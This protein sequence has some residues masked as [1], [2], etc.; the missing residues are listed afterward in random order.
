MAKGDTK[1]NQYLD[2]AANGSRADLPSD[3][4]CETRSQ[5][6]I[7]E[8]AE[9]VMDVEDEVEEIKNNPDVVDIVDTYADL[10]DYDTSGLTDNDIIRVLN[11]ETRDGDSTYYRWSASTQSWAYIG[12]AGGA[13][14]TFTT[15]TDADVNYHDEA[16]GEDFIALWLLESGRYALA[17]DATVSLLLRLDENDTPT[18]YFS[19]ET[20]PI[21]LVFG[22]QNAVFYTG[23]A[24][25]ADVDPETGQSTDFTI[26]SQPFVGTDGT[27][28]GRQ[29]L[30]PTPE[31]IDAGMFLSSSGAWEAISGGIKE[32]TTDDYNWP[33]TGTPTSVALWLLDDGV[34]SFNNIQVRYNASMGYTSSGLAIT[35]KTTVSSGIGNGQVL[36]MPNGDLPRF[37]T[38]IRIDGT[39]ETQRIFPV[40][41]NNLTTVVSN[42][43]LD[44]RQGKVLKDMI[45]NLPT[46]GGITELTTADYNYPADN[47]DGIALWKLGEGLYSLPTTTGLKVYYGA[48]L[49]TSNNAT[50]DVYI[51]GPTTS[52]SKKVFGVLKNYSSPYQINY[53]N[54]N[55]G[56]GTSTFIPS[57]VQS[58]GTSQTDVMSQNAV[59]SM[60]YAD[61]NTRTRVQIGVGASAPQSA[62]YATAIGREA[63]ALSDR[64]VTLGTSARV[65]G[66][67]YSVA[68]A[69]GLVENQQGVF[70][71]G[72]N[73]YAGQATSGYNNSAYRLLTGLYDGQSAHDAATVAQGNTLATAAPT[74]ATEGVLG[75][76]YTDTTN[77]HTYQ[78]TSIDATDPSN[79]VYNWTQRW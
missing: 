9:R 7:R 67:P 28:P 69:Y 13:T 63:E 37:V 41:A 33:T 51:V 70:Q 10:E 74:T 29:G 48:D 66:S 14:Q 8:V 36:Y 19:P 55:T 25:I 12:S 57:V 54:V 53:G 45:D 26:L 60:V 5:T 17:E 47:P 56:T 77:M 64:S 32:L 46:G 79:P 2:I 42:Y 71:I 39:G 18:E 38:Q 23:G 68:L 22:S 4:C 43:A 3:T 73:R 31:S 61:P 6:L 35:K 21:A 34:Y 72:L 62:T 40:L 76:L 16:S 49:G 58:N 20:R 78:C 44:A 50:G 65:T 30:V 24:S 52:S 27:E 1:T 75:Q 15:L 11:D 59:T